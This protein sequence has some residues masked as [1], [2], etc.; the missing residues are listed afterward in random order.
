V[1]Y[2]LARPELMFAKKM[3]ADGTAL[4]IIIRGEFGVSPF[5]GQLSGKQSA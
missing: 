3:P 1:F 2:V 5:R 4:P